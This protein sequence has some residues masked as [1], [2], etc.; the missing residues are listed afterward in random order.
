MRRLGIATTS[1]V[2]VLALVTGTEVGAAGA[3]GGTQNWDGRSY[4]GEPAQGKDV[5]ISPDG[6]TTYVTGSTSFT[7]DGEAVVI[8]RDA[9]SG[10]RKWAATWSD[11]DHPEE[12]ASGEKLVVSPDGS[13]VYLLGQLLECTGCT[14]AYHWLAIAFD[15]VTG[16]RLWVSRL[17]GAGPPSSLVVSDDGSTL[18]ANGDYLGNGSQ[19]IAIDAASGDLRWRDE[20][21][22]VYPALGSALALS[23]DQTSVLAL[24]MSYASD[25]CAERRSRHV[26]ESFDLATGEERFS[27]PITCGEASSL[28]LG[29]GGASVLVAGVTSEYTSRLQVVAYDAAT[30]T[31]Q[32]AFRPAGGPATFE[33][34]PFVATSPDGSVAYVTGDVLTGG[35]RRLWTVRTY[36]LDVS[37]GDVTWAGRYENGGD[38]HA[39]RLAVSP[40]GSAVFVTGFEQQRCGTSC[41]EQDSAGILLAYD[42]ASGRERWAA[43]YAGGIGADVVSSPD[44]SRAYMAGRLVP[45]SSSS[46]RSARRAAQCSTAVCGVASASY[47]NAT[48]SYQTEDSD[49]GVRWSGWAGRF[50]GDALGG[51]D[52]A[53]RAPGAAATFASPATRTVTW[54]TRQGPTMGKAQVLVDGKAKATVDLYAR[55]YARKVVT[56]T[57]LAPRTHQVRV[58]VTGRRNAAS[59]GT[60]V[61]TD[62]F[63]TRVGTDTRQEH[64]SQVGLGSWR[65]LRRPSAN[66]GS[67]RWSDRSDARASM[68]FRGGRVQLVTARGPAY[69][70]VRV[71]VDGVGR[72]VDLYS[73]TRVW[74]VPIAFTGLGAGSHT[75]TVSPLGTKNRRSTGRAVVID[76]F[77]VRP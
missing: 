21:R 17:Q 26:L 52:R 67:V 4:V 1:A 27:R 34:A 44:G 40:D 75:I 59:R 77:V 71:V 74:R 41:T 62:A 10:A 32:W 39:T 14:A 51:A 24:G 31:E 66:G 30:G 38:S 29:A 42:A 8:A 63:A 12:W 28:S 33:T 22:G 60:W 57:G 56:L 72:T 45:P 68:T 13:T 61:V 2:L 53:S 73:A 9:R 69:G 76:A 16:D 64:A 43:L 46:G 58:V 49:V 3:S 48:T 50:V 47:N 19:T 18:V 54:V 5:A 25:A 70:K 23:A 65:T 36:A 55:N 6:A 20:S 11:S 35:S 37:T 7:S 15:A